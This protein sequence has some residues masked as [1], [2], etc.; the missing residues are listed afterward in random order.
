MKPQ[1]CRALLFLRCRSNS[2]ARALELQRAST[3]REELRVQLT[4]NRAATLTCA[5]SCLRSVD[6]RT[7]C[8]ET[9]DARA[10]LTVGVLQAAVRSALRPNSRSRSR[11][12][13][14]RPGAGS[15][16]ARRSRDGPGRTGPEAAWPLA[17]PLP[18]RRTAPRVGEAEGR[19]GAAGPRNSSQ[20]GL[21]SVLREA[22]PPLGGARR[23]PG[24]R[25][26]GGGGRRIRRSGPFFRGPL[27][28][29]R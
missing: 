11:P 23:H 12:M 10:L 29:N 8:R 16:E 25:A 22:L 15:S 3:D 2:F 18:D 4:G 21:R 1:G 14:Q 24:R 26:L 20:L 9:H 7:M 19:A 6:S 28:S 5:S 17:H 27:S 13:C